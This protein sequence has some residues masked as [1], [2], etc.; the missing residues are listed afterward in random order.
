VLLTGSNDRD[1]DLQEGLLRAFT[2][3]RVDGLIIVPSVSESASRQHVLIDHIP[4]VY[5][6]GLPRTPGADAVISDNE[7]GT[8]LAVEHL[9]AI[10]H[11][12][13][14][15]IGD[16]QF[17][18]SARER[19]RGFREAML[20]RGT[21]PATDRFVLDIEN[22]LSARRA[23]RRL[24]HSG[25]APTAIIC[26]N[27]TTLSG[28][29]HEIHAGGEQDSVALIGFDDHEMASVVRPGITVIAQDET[30]L[31][32][33]IVDRLFL[34]LESPAATRREILRVPVSLISRGSGE[35]FVQTRLS[36]R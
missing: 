6:D 10:G 32:E 27:N 4:T 1:A 9:W 8:R 7:G 11:R 28:A 22:Q 20:E 30:K 2:A 33:T 14:A 5:I 34:R 3:R 25:V 29:L 12:D 21:I 31:A 15:Y 24:L 13:I 36:L 23:A 17:M 26:G 18:S 19:A 16:A 35:V